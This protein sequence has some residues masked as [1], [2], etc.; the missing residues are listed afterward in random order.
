MTQAA[1]A[2]VNTGINLK[3]YSTFFYVE[4]RVNPKRPWCRVVS[5]G[6][7]CI[8]RKRGVAEREAVKLEKRLRA[9]LN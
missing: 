2:R 6:K 5:K 7:W 4:A 9:K 3:T 1:L 8:H